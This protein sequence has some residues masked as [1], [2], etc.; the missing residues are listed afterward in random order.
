MEDILDWLL[1]EAGQVLS[2]LLSASS[3]LVSLGTQFFVQLLGWVA[4]IVPGWLSIPLQALQSA[5]LSHNILANVVRVTTFLISGFIDPTL[6]LEGL[7]FLF[8]VWFMAHFLHFVMWV[9]GIV[10][11]NSG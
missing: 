9:K 7:S 6:L 8:A 10:W 3:F 5:F 1:V 4:G 11:P 2:F